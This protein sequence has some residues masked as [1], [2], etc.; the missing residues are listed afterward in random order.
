MLLHVIFLSNTLY[1]NTEPKP[2]KQDF[3][4]H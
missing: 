4:V 1:Y 2:N 3:T